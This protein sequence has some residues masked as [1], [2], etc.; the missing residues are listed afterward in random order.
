MALTSAPIEVKR[1]VA[2]PKRGQFRT[3]E[4]LFCLKHTGL[5]SGTKTYV[6]YNLGRRDGE[7]MFKSP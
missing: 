3:G 5:G 6:H 1:K 7:K 4:D 2:R